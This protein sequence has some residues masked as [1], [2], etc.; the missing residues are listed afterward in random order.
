MTHHNNQ[1]SLEQTIRHTETALFGAINFKSSIVPMWLCLDDFSRVD[2]EDLRLVA[3]ETEQQWALLREVLR[4][5]EIPFG[6]VEGDKIDA[7][8]EDI[9]RIKKIFSSDWFLAYSKQLVVGSI[10]IVEFRNFSA[11]V[12]RLLDV[13]ILPQFQGRGHGNQLLSAVCGE[14]RRR[15]LAALCLRAEEDRWV[16]DWYTR[17][18]FKSVGLWPATNLVEARIDG[19]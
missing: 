15:S 2:L 12:G 3:V 4:Q 6:V 8:I 18:G 11:P 17:L 13:D 5:I 16:K 14:A 19:E 7:I 9:R 10:G 1:E